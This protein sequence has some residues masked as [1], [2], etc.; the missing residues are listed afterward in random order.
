L[1]KIAHCSFAAARGARHAAERSDIR[2]N[3]Q[4]WLQVIV[5]WTKAWAP[6]AAAKEAQ[7]LEFGEVRY[8]FRQAGTIKATRVHGAIL[9][10]AAMRSA[11]HSLISVS[12]Q[13]TARGP[14]FIGAGNRPTF[15]SA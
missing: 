12:S 4:A 15:A 1:G 3:S 6:D 14:M 8:R 5:K 10:L 13:P 7:P 11:S 9:R 2:V